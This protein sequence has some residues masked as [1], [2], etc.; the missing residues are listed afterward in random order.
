MQTTDGFHIIRL[1]AGRQPF[2][3]DFSSVSKEIEQRIRKEDL[4]AKRT[5]FIASLR[6]RTKVKINQDVLDTIR[7]ELT[8]SSE[9]AGVGGL[10]GGSNIPV[11]PGQ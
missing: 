1:V 2:S 7:Q 10:G 3:R 9:Q 11:L 5:S 8:D 6:K 4:S